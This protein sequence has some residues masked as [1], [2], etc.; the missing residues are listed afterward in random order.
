MRDTLVKRFLNSCSDN[1]KS[2]TCTERSRRI[3]NPKWAMLFAIFVALT[4]CGTRAEPQQ[5]TKV[6]RIG[7]LSASSPSADSSI[8]AF[9]QGLRELGYE[10]GKNIAIEYRYAEGRMERLPDLAAELVR[11]KV[12][13]IVSPGIQPSRAAKQATT[14]IPIVFPGVGDPV[15][16]GLVESLA[17]PGGNVTGMTN[18]SPELTGKR[19]E[20]LKEALPR[21]SR[22]AVLRDPRQPPQSFNETQIASQSFGLKLQS[23][24]IRDA[25]DVETAFSAMSRERV[26][27]FITLPQTVINLHRR[28]IL[29][30]AGK[31]RLPST[32]GD[33]VWVE[34]GGLMSYGPDIIDIHRRAATYVDKI[35]KG[36][37]PADLPVEQPTKFEFIVNLKTAKQIGLTIPP[38]VLV[39]ADRVIR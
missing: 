16:W 32:H 30:L 11:L 6:A 39:R 23:L 20:L 18:F 7:F 27:A 36:T 8:A 2:K 4:V 9:R 25:A 14:T 34:A 17:R 21:I 5:S 33:K 35:L 15:A 1:L 28:R 31:S 12:G 26:G 24:E 38:N 29:E 22:V 13:V 19:V 37:K 3:E 10:E